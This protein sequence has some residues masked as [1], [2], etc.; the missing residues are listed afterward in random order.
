MNNEK[1]LNIGCGGTLHPEW[2]NVDI[3]ASMPGVHAHDVRCGLPY[4]DRMF[5]A[6]Y[7]SHM[8][9]HVTKDQAKIIVG[10]A[11]RVLKNGGIAR[12]VVPDIEQ[13]VRLYLKALEDVAS[14]QNKREADYDWMILELFDQTVRATSG[15]EMGVYLSNPALSNKEFIISRIGMEAKR[16]WDRNLV[17]KNTYIWNKLKSMKVSWFVNQL[18]IEIACFFVWIFA[19]ADAKKA[20][21]E[22]L[23]RESGEIHRWMYDRFSLQR[24]LNQAGFVDV[25]VCNADVSSIPAFNSYELDILDNKVRKPDSLYIEAV[26]P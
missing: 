18:R 8:L 4:D 16:I 15:G 7:C 19:G 5:D 1:L 12:F 13:I 26:K 14:G 3:V 2:V 22:G 11:Y 24:L 21:R 9:E 25:K 17:S 20:F 23:F 10:E 6:C